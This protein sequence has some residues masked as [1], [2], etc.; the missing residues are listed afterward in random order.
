TDATCRAWLAH[1]RPRPAAAG[2]R[3]HALTGTPP[4]TE[5]DS[6]P[7]PGEQPGAAAVILTI[8]EPHQPD[9]FEQVAWRQLMR[10][11]GIL[12]VLTHSDHDTGQLRDPT[13]PLIR[14]AR[15]GGLAWLDHI[16][17]TGHRPQPAVENHT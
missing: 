9:R 7:T 12:A 13:T 15:R 4:P 14:A 1:R 10:P 16:I 8:V 11:G 5:N 6:H 2:R 3:L 17:I